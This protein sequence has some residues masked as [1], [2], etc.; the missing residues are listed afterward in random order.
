MAENDFKLKVG[1]DISEVSIQNINADIRIIENKVQP[2]TL[3]VNVDEDSLKSVL[4]KI[5]SKFSIGLTPSDSSEIHE[6]GSRSS[7]KTNVPNLNKMGKRLTTMQNSLQKIGGEA[8]KLEDSIKNLQDRITELNNIGNIDLFDENQ[9]AELQSIIVAMN[10][11][12]ES[13]NKIKTEANKGFFDAA[14]TGKLDAARNKLRELVSK[15]PKLLTDEDFRIKYDKINS[16]DFSKLDKGKKTVTETVNEIKN[17]DSAARQSGN[18]VDTLGQRFETIFKNSSISAV[19]AALLQSAKQ[20]VVQMVDNV[21][22]LDSA[23]TELKKVTNETSVEYDEFFKKAKRQAQEI[24]SSLTDAI[25]ATADFARLGY[26]MEEAAE[27]SR[28]SIIYKNVGDGFENVTE[29][30]ESLISIMK[31]FGVEAEN[32]I[33]IADKL[34]NIGNNNAISSGGLGRALQTSASALMEAGASMEEAMALVSGANGVIQDPS[35]VGAGLRTNDCPYV[36]KCA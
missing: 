26:N 15:Y 22:K 18:A 13:F 33:T 24:G 31:A 6:A 20:A 1:L 11:L 19:V 21:R 5:S 8:L 9:K 28:V 27:L 32:V 29:S 30:S 23:M 17:L 35:Q 25:T 2:I 7:T 34:N 10:D 36:Q 4:N 12:E 16:M 3:K 14:Q